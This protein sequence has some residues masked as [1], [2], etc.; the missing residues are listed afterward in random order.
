MPAV[1]IEP[2]PGAVGIARGEEARRPSP[3]SSDT[4]SRQLGGAG[5]RLAHP[6]RDGRRRVAGVADPHHAGLDPADLPRVGAEQED[7]AGH[8]L[9]RPVLVDGADERVVGLG[10]DAV[11]AGLGDGAARGDRGEAGALAG[12]AARR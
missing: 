12:R 4:S 5:R 3:R 7:V 8:R 6:E 10:D 9:D 2:A 1:S 11:V